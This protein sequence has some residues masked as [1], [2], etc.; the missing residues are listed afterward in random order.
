MKK[1]WFEPE[2]SRH[3]GPVKAPEE[4]WDRVQNHEVARTPRPARMWLTSMGYAWASAAALV[5]VALAVT[6]TLRVRSQE[7]VSNEELAVRALL[8][9]P[10]GLGLHSGQ[11]SEIRAWIKAGTGIDLP[12]QMRS[13]GMIQ[14]YG[15]SM[16][17][18]DA[19]TAEISYRVGDMDVA[20]VVSK[21][22]SGQDV[23]HSVLAI[24]AD[25]GVKYQSWEMHGQRYTV[26]AANSAVACFL[27]HANGP[28][29]GR[30]AA[31]LN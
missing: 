23:R 16:I 29:A 25:Q 27:C 8:R 22:S 9:G 12:E 7:N 31:M 30:P 6:W 21:M 15:A 24:G 13:S 3:I 1:E 5:V 4:L 28:P 11:A 20:L 10:D 17:R 18:K 14:L 19:P 26:A 2:L